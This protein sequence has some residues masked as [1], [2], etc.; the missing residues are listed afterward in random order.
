LAL[1]RRFAAMAAAGIAFSVAAT[2]PV[3]AGTVTVRGIEMNRFGRIM[4]EFDQATKVQVRAA[5]G[6]LVLNFPKSTKVQGERLTRELPSY[7][8]QVRHDP[9]GLGLRLALT[10]PWRA[11]VLEAAEKV[12]IDLLPANWSGLLP[13]LP[14]EVID[15]LARRARDAE[16]KA[17]VEARA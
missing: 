1:V 8:A 13:S 4:L 17:G 11:N 5:N 7:L 12:F 16:A 3:F 15:A 10:Q 6:V 2:A 14:P 9:D